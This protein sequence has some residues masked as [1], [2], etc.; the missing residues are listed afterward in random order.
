LQNR[1]AGVNAILRLAMLAGLRMEL[2]TILSTLADLML[3]V[4]PYDR[5]LVYFWDEEHEKV[6]LRGFQ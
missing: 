1:A 3:E 6:R 2:E 4:V 5:M